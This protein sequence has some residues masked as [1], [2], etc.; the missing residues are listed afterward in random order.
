M[1]PAGSETVD[2]DRAAGCRGSTLR[3]GGGAVRMSLAPWL[4]SYPDAA[5]AQPAVSLAVASLLICGLGTRAVSILLALAVPISQ[6]AMQLD[7]RL[8]WLLALC[9]LILYGP[10]PFALDRL[11]D[12][13]YGESTVTRRSTTRA[14]RM[15]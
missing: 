2:C 11:V 15:S 9:I 7:E 8:Y 5:A 3:S 13:L 12:Q 10:G 4:A 14:C 6:A 1:V